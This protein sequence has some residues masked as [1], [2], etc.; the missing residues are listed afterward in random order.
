MVAEIRG[1]S[2]RSDNNQAHTLMNKTDTNVEKTIAHLIYG[3]LPEP[4]IHLNINITVYVNI[5]IGRYANFITFSMR[6][7]GMI[8][9]QNYLNVI[10][11][12]TFEEKASFIS[13]LKQK[14]C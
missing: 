9:N 6:K 7:N 12:I 13:N 14:T 11:A 1:K 5:R 2:K 8:T 4:Q 3:S 10:C